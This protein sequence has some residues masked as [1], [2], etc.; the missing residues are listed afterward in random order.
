MHMSRVSS[1]KIS[2]RWQI[3]FK[4][5]EG[6]PGCMHTISRKKSMKIIL[7]H[8]KANLKIAFVLDIGMCPCVCV[9]SEGIYKK[10][11]HNIDPV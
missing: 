4:V 11:W 7:S 1:R 8:F 3:V 5:S 10:Q 2:M 6:Y 9:C